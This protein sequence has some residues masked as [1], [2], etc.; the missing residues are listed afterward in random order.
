MSLRRS[1]PG[2]FLRSFE[3]CS[4][5]PLGERRLTEGGDHTADLRLLIL[6][7]RSAGLFGVQPADKVGLRIAAALQHQ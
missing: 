7:R 2:S 5:V 6:R 3:R 4:R 1:F